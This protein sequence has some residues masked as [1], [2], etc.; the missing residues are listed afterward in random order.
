M[1]IRR[2]NRGFIIF[3][4]FL[5]IMGGIYTMVFAACQIPVTEPVQIDD[6]PAAFV[7]TVELPVFIPDTTLV[8]E[9]IVS[10]DGHYVEDGSEDYVRDIAALYLHNSGSTMVAA[11]RVIVQLE[12]GLYRFEATCIPPGATVLV[13]EKDRKP[14]SDIAIYSVGGSASKGIKTDINGDVIFT[15][16]FMAGLRIYN[17]SDEDYEAICISHKN[18]L[19]EENI[20]IGGITYV[21]YAH[22]LNGGGHCD[23]WPV[24]FGAESKIVCITGNKMDAQ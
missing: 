21:T 17:V 18:F 13:L 12:W 15:Q 20:Y 16:D 4:A 8:V 23:I 11:C 2:I 3:T 5:F 1:Y 10:Y 9:R 19:P 14:Y 22:S 6:A 7:D 24:H